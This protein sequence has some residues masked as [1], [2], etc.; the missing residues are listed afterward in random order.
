ME[1]ITKYCRTWF[2]CN[3]GGLQTIFTNLGYLQ[4]NDG[5]SNDEG[6]ED[7]QVEELRIIDISGFMTMNVNVL[8]TNDTLNI[9]NEL[10]NSFALME[11]SL[12]QL[13]D[14][15]QKIINECKGG[16][17]QLC[18]HAKSSLKVVAL[19]IWNIWLTR[20]NESLHLGMVFQCVDDGMANSINQMKDW[21]M[22]P[23]S[24]KW[25]LVKREIVNR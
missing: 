12:F 21:H 19:N 10:E 9:I 16:G 25:T 13:Q 5:T 11:K 15:M 22:N 24:S 7:T 8:D 17:I 1:N 6:N 2:G 4:L 23:C 3:H 18:E 20:A 14:K